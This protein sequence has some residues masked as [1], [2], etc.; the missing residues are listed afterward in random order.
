MLSNNRTRLV[1]LI[2]GLAVVVGSLAWWR[3]QASLYDFEF[4]RTHP[5]DAPGTLD[6]IGQL[7]EG[8]DPLCTATLVADRWAITS[9]GCLWNPDTADWRSPGSL[10]VR[11]AGNGTRFKAESPVIA[12]SMAD[13]VKSP[14]DFKNGRFDW[15]ILELAD[16]VS[17]RIKPLP[18]E[19][20]T[21]QV[22]GLIGAQGWLIYAIGYPASN[23]DDRLVHSACHVLEMS[24]DQRMI[25]N[26]CVSS[27]L[28]D[29]ASMP[30]M[31]R[32]EGVYHVMGIQ[33]R[34]VTYKDK[35][36]GFAAGGLAIYER[37]AELRGKNA[38]SEG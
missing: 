24:E 34:R 31:A 15:A 22:H 10:F 29:P 38:D 1:A 26:S 35:V 7:T 14:E 23:P 18:L 19:R 16:D 5:A 8:D 33:S 12:V 32:R 20:L 30:V 27:G 13:S 6:A 3:Y 9:A 36:F 37:L 2:L 28:D 21:R 11:L 17:D 25:L 4:P